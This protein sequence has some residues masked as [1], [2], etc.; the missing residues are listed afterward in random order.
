MLIN[1]ILHYASLKD[2]DIFSCS[3]NKHDLIFMILTKALLRYWA[4]KKCFIYPANLNSVSALP[5]K[6]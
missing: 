5:G 1:L 4:I 2:P 3:L 6:T